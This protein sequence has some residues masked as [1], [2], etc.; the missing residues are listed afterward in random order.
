MDSTAPTTQRPRSARALTPLLLLILLF[1]Q[2]TA[3]PAFLVLPGGCA[4]TSKSRLSSTTTSTTRGKDITPLGRALAPCWSTAGGA[5]DAAA[6]GGDG[7]ERAITLHTLEL[8]LLDDPSEYRS[9]L[10]ARF[11]GATLLRWHL[12]EVVERGGGDRVTLAEVVIVEHRG[13]K[14]MGVNPG[15]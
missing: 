10:Q 7:Q 15:Q 11:P 2:F 13:S 5:S 3:A 9:V 6:E 14:A 12:S 8:P 1:V 4:P